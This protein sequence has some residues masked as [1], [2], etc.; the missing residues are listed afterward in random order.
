MPKLTKGPRLISGWG[1]GAMIKAEIRLDD[2]CKNGHDSFSITGEIYIPKRRDCEACGCLHDEIAEKF[3][4]LAPFIRWHLTSTDGPMHYLANAM[5]HAG[6]CLGMESSR[7]IEHLKSTI[8]FGA[9]AGDAAVDLDKLDGAGLLAFLTNRFPALMQ[10]FK[11]DMNALF[12]DEVVKDVAA[13]PYPY[14]QKVS[15]PETREAARQKKRQ[16]LIDDAAKKSQQRQAEL[17]GKLWLMDHGL[18]IENVIYYSHRD[19]FTFGWRELL[20]FEEQSAIRDVISEF[21]FEYELKTKDLG[22]L[23]GRE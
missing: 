7:N 21:P 13:E 6:F 3:P 4:E 12:G 18:D 11:A 19:I 20:T 15:T 5:Y 17:D 23:S 2:E 9:V 8:V 16:G 14:T 22:T 10:Q 1:N